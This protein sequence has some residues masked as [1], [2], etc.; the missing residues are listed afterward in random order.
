MVWLFKTNGLS[1]LGKE[2]CFYVKIYNIN[3]IIN[4]WKKIELKVIIMNNESKTNIN[5]DN[6]TYGKLPTSLYK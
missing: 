5:W 3:Y 2:I 4:V 1:I 6:P